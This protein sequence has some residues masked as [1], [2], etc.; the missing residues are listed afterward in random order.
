MSDIIDLTHISDDDH[1]PTFIIRDQWITHIQH[2]IDEALSHVITQSEFLLFSDTPILCH[3]AD[4]V[5]SLHQATRYS[6]THGLCE[7]AAYHE[8]HPPAEIL[9]THPN[10]PSDTHDDDDSEQGYS[11]ASDIPSFRDQAQITH[12]ALNAAAQ[13]VASP[14]YDPQHPAVDD[15]VILMDINIHIPDDQPIYVF[16]TPTSTFEHSLNDVL[17]SVSLTGALHNYLHTNTHIPSTALS[18]LQKH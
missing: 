11:L 2:T 15:L 10:A 14:Y 16:Q 6:L 4:L 9:V 12:L 3:N 17:Q 5:C 13:L 18:Q 7:I 8:D 1:N